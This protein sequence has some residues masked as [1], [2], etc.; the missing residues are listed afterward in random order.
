MMDH[1]RNSDPNYRIY[2]ERAKALRARAFAAFLS[3]AGRTL[4]RAP[5]SL[6]RMLACRR[7]RIAAERE[8]QALDDTTLKDIGLSRSQIGSAVAATL[9]EECGGADAGGGDRMAA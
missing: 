2:I 1:Y 6:W 3:H 4:W 5:R 9:P 7:R 8:L